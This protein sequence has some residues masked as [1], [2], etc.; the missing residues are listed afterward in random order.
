MGTRTK[1][2]YPGCI[3]ISY[4]DAKIAKELDA[5]YNAFTPP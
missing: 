3:A 4:Y 2:G 5:L 1:V